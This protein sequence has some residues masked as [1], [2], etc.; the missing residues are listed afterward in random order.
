MMKVVGMGEALWDVFPEGKKIGGAPANFA[1]HAAQF[2]LEGIAVSAIGKDVLGDEIVAAFEESGLDYRL[3]R[4]DFPTGT[5]QVELDGAGVPSYIIKEGAAWDNIPFTPEIEELAR[6]QC[7][8]SLR[9]SR[10]G[11]DSRD[12]YFA[13]ASVIREARSL[14]PSRMRSGVINEK[15]SLIVFCPVPSVW[16]NDPATY[17]TPASRAVS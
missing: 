7:R 16:K 11:P 3:E 14:M 8:D 1:Y 9:S 2:G 10:T 17:A 4:V 5:V 6:A 13:K 15:F 12:F